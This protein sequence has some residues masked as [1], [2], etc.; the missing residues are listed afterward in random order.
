MIQCQCCEG[1]RRRRRLTKDRRRGKDSSPA[2]EV[3]G[4]VRSRKR[5][6]EGTLRERR[7]RESEV[8][9]QLA[10][11]SSTAKAQQA[12]DGQEGRDERFGRGGD[13]VVD[14]VVFGTAASNDSV[15]GFV[16]LRRVVVSSRR[17]PPHERGRT[18]VLRNAGMAITPPTFDVSYLF[19]N[20]SARRPC[21]GRRRR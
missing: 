21:T 4:Y 11:L 8:S 13:A 7:E 2:T 12:Y 18:N 16:S 1:R 20:R 15:W 17:D 19:R 5:A 9:E 14:A 6:E 10:D 3:V